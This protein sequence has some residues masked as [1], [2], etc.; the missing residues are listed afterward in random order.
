MVLI[1]HHVSSRRLVTSLL[2]RVLLLS[3]IVGTDVIS[4]LKFATVSVYVSDQFM[5]LQAG[6]AWRGPVAAGKRGRGEGKRCGSSLFRCPVGAIGQRRIR[7]SPTPGAP[8]LAGTRLIPRCRASERGRFYPWPAIAG[9]G[10]A[11]G[12]SPPACSNLNLDPEG[13]QQGR[14]SRPPPLGPAG[15]RTTARLWISTTSSGH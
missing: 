5:D 7:P 10:T 6:P 9:A 14:Y 4:L 12:A 2:S 13:D 15:W 3:Q 8:V 1:E 11:T